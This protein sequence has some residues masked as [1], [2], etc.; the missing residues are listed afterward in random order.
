VWILTINIIEEEQ[1]EIIID[2][3]SLKLFTLEEC[4]I[5]IELYQKAAVLK[6]EESLKYSLEHWV[7]FE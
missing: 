4:I 3:I 1:E 7:Y 2:T 5:Q 6:D